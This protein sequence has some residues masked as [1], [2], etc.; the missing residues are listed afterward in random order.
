MN[1]TAQP[2]QTECDRRPRPRPHYVNQPIAIRR[3]RERA[4]SDFR[5]SMQQEVRGTQP[6]KH[7]AS[8]LKEKSG[9][10]L[11]RE[12]SVSHRLL[13]RTAAAPRHIRV[14]RCAPD[15]CKRGAGREQQGSSGEGSTPPENTVAHDVIHDRPFPVVLNDHVL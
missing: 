13:F 2:N 1:Y 7:C 4:A 14:A 11:G 5:R 15:A 6:K 12:R 8:E 10:R 9:P 3:D